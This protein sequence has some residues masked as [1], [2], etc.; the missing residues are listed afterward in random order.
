MV[1]TYIREKKAG[2]ARALLC[3]LFAVLIAAGCISRGC[4]ES[5]AQN[6]PAGSSNS[7]QTVDPF[8]Y[9]E[10]YSAVLYDNRSG[11]PTS[12]ANA[13][14][15][16]SEGFIWI[17]S[18]AG[19]VRYDGNTF[20]FFDSAM[21]IS[22]VR[23]LFVDEQDRLWIGTNDS[24]VFLMA[25]GEVQKWNKKDGLKS[26]SIRAITEDGNGTVYIG[27]I[28]GISMID[29]ALNLSVLQDERI[30]EQTIRDI[31]KG[32]DG[33]IYGLTEAGDLFTAK[34]GKLVTFLSHE[35]CRIEDIIAIFPDPRRPG[36][37]YVGTGNSQVYH[38]SLERNFASLG[39]RDIAPLSYVE[40]FEAINGQIWICAGNGIGK[41]DAEGFHSL[42]N[43]P[44]NNSVG[45]VMPDY[46]GN[47]WFT[48]T[49]QGVMKIVRNQ[50]SDLFERYSL[51]AEVV[52]STC[53][54]NQQ[55]FIG[56]DSGLIVLD[57]GRK[58]NRIPVTKAVTASG[59]ELEITD[60]LEYL[61]GV[62]IRSIIRDSKG[63]IWIST[64]RKYG[65]IRYDSGEALVFTPEDGLHSNR[66]RMVSE[67]GDGS[68][69]VAN[70][71]GLSIIADDRVTAGYGKKDG[72]DITEILCVVEGFNHDMILGSDGGGIY[73]ISPDG[74][75]HIGIDE[76]LASEVILR[77]KRSLS[78]D[79]YWIVTGNSLAFM[80]PDY[81]VTTIQ[82]FPY[83]NNY[84]LYENSKGDVWVI[85]S[86]GIYEI[87]SDELLAN[88][89]IKPVFH[90]IA[91]GLP[92]VA[93]ANSFSELTS[94][95]DL[96]IA[97]SV[98]VVKV[99][100]EK[101]FENLS[102]LK[103]A[104]PYIDADS[105]RFYPDETG[106][107]L[108]PADV[109]KLT[110][111]PRVFNY[112]LINPQV[113]YRLKGFDL[114]DT[115]VSQQ[116]LVPVDYTNLPNGTY[117]FNM[118]IKDPAGQAD[119]TLSFQIV[120][121]K[122]TSVGAAGN[123]I[124]N[125]AALFFMAGILIYASLFRKRGKPDD[126]LFY[127][128]LFSNM[129]L[130]AADEASGLLES[131]IFPG[132]RLLMIAVN[133]LSFICCAVFPYLLLLYLRC[134]IDQEKVTINKRTILYGI[135]CFLLIVLQIINLKTGWVFFIGKDN[136]Y[137]FGPLSD[138][139]FLPVAFY[140]LLSLIWIGRTDTRLILP[141]ILLIAARI[142]LG[143]WI[144]DI[145][146]TAF[147]HTALLICIQISIMSRP[148][149]KEEAL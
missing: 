110:I 1:T 73:V 53:M 107:F 51:S 14:A 57:N 121:G 42:E 61:A 38:G 40:R 49:R 25:R 145:F 142:C 45:H 138:L 37:L 143:L 17:G 83:P 86:N 12:E 140:Y 96:Y 85:S 34:D 4:A 104:L 146:S 47:L 111:Y 135:P 98:G 29:S 46:E 80:T 124:I 74:T 72:I 11:L 60:L 84:D 120:K 32:A 113:S 137:H 87:S 71:G 2:P 125:T 103:V 5:G 19:L 148:L 136:I 130:A 147:I 149:N 93:T 52:N 119:K 55:L 94:D 82:E 76:G 24:G 88:G 75:K 106:S 7:I 131:S 123:I 3:L 56:T 33:M 122:E 64:W 133:M 28:A 10:R 68:M 69:L 99:N 100:I 144:R 77:I 21:G 101:P 54:Y 78:R 22:N 23:C 6:T 92:Y 132:S 20:E 30:D 128:M 62:R 126:K 129:I 114:T 141:G 35:E 27:S 8:R 105:K 44:M 59:T 109:H 118:L 63:R 50:F 15:Q 97:S 91:N 16:T 65:L 95:G 48:S 26:V 81:Q 134:R 31:R 13:I 66:V 127:A 108:I 102:A 79:I 39:V 18:Y 41:I 58:V 112:L 89:P 9:S 115:T 90:G 116:D 67:C 139:V 117:H 43:V 70:T 36:D